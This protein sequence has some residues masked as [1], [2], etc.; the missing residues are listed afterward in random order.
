M[1]FISTAQHKFME[2][3]TRVPFHNMPQDRTSSNFHQGF[4]PELGFLSDSSSLS[5]GQNYHFH[6]FTTPS[7]AHF[8]AAIVIPGTIYP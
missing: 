4:R 7:K 1:P 3:E 5:S 6:L 8:P 2:S